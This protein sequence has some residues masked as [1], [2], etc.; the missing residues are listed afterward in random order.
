MTGMRGTAAAVMLVLAIGTF[1]DPSESCSLPDPCTSCK[2]HEE[3]LNQLTTF[4][5]ISE[6][7]SISRAARSLGLS[8]AMASRHL[9]A[10]ENELGVKLMRRTTRRL[11]LTE[12]GRELLTRSRKLLAD[13]EETKDALRPGSGIMGEVVV[14]M[15]GCFGTQLVVPLLPKLLSTHPQ[16]RVDL[17]FEDRQVDIMLDGV[18][19]AIRMNAPQDSPFLVARH[20]ATFECVLCASPKFLRDHG[21]IKAVEQLS[22][23][24]C[25][26]QEPRPASWS[27][28]T[29]LGSESVAVDGRLRTS[30]LVAT[31]AAILAGM[32]IGWVPLCGAAPDDFRQKALVRVLPTAALSPVPVHGIY[33]KQSRGAFAVQAVLSFLAE[34]LPKAVR[35]QSRRATT[36][37]RATT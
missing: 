20:L 19:V 11:D 7:G 18:D 12:A 15:P 14:S 16:L 8:V 21:P 35:P 34:E 10:L 24:P 2:D 23:V 30:N 1:T 32:G 4:V 37:V 17:R 9:L 27:F 36:R 5:R 31:R 26:V 29:P 25:V 6:M 28:E 33:H 3:M 22:K 13:V